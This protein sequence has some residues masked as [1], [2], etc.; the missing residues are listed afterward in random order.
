MYSRLWR[1]N[2]YGS[3]VSLTFP[4]S[5]FRGPWKRSG[6]RSNRLPLFSQWRLPRN[7]GRSL[8]CITSPSK[9]SESTLIFG[10][11]SPPPSPKNRAFFTGCSVFTS[12]LIVLPCKLVS[13]NF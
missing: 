2:A 9:P 4:L 3:I 11:L 8:T 6:L 7:R 13:I 1:S 5:C 10:L 12:A